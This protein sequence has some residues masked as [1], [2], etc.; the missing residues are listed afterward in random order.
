MQKHTNN[1]LCSPQCST[2][3]LTPSRSTVSSICA[4]T[5]ISGEW[6]SQTVSV[7]ASVCLA[8]AMDME[9]LALKSLHPAAWTSSDPT[10]ESHFVQRRTIFSDLGSF[11][12]YR[13][14]S[15]RLDR[16]YLMA[17]TMGITE[18]SKS[19]LHY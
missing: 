8:M 3:R 1:P 13:S 15:N 5:R 10:K 6:I 2:N 16:T 19:I 17:S 11:S 12:T 9:T 18:R 14:I 7:S 4:E